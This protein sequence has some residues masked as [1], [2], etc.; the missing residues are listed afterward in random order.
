MTKKIANTVSSHQTPYCH[1]LEA[2]KIELAKNCLK[3]PNLIVKSAF[4]TSLSNPCLVMPL[5]LPKNPLPVSGNKS[6]KWPKFHK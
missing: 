2:Y 1:K 6:Q 5:E 4:L 3:K